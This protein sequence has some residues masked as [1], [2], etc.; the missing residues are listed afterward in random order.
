MTVAARITV[1]GAGTMGHGIAQTAI[2][3]GFRGPLC[4]TQGDARERGVEALPAC[5]HVMP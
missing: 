2:A 4:D 3:S 1:I 5:R